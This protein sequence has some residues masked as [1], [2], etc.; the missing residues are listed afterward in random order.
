LGR[1]DLTVLLVGDYESKGGYARE[2]QKQID[3]HG[4]GWTIRLVGACDD[5]PAV[6]KIADLVVCPSVTPEGFGRT[7]AE[8][9]AMGKPVIVT[10]LGAPPELVA[11]GETGWVVPAGDAEALAEAIART[12]ALPEHVLVEMG[13]RG[14]A[15]VQNRYTREHMCNATLALYDELLVASLFQDESASVPSPATDF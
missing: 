4:L 14:M 13:R 10:D 8:A 1:D 2:L 3:S 11:H 12:L 5:M 7:V 15:E 9:M 6:Y